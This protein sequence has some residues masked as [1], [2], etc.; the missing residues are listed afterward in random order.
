MTFVHV[1]DEDQIDDE[2]RRENNVREDTPVLESH[3]FIIGFLLYHYCRFYE[4]DL[5][6]MLAIIAHTPFDEIES[7]PTHY[8]AIFEAIET[9]EELNQMFRDLGIPFEDEV[10]ETGECE[11]EFRT[12][13]VEGES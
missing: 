3:D 11:P 2:F 9:E 6:D 1:H 8:V 13:R 5:T 4:S 12:E 10:A 7:Q